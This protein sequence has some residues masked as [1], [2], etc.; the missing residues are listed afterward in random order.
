[1]E[2]KG[3]AMKGVTRGTAVFPVV[4]A[5]VAVPVAIVVWT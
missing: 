1:V 5:A 2:G 4:V 3:E